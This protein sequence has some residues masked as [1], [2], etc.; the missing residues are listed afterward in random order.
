MQRRIQQLIGFVLLMFLVVGMRLAP[1]LG[2]RVSD[3]VA[4]ISTPEL[5]SEFSPL[6]LEEAPKPPG[7][8]SPLD[9]PQ[10]SS[11]RIFKDLENLAF[12]RYSESQREQARQYI[13]NELAAA[14]WEVQQQEFA[15]GINVYADRPGTDPEAGRILVAAHYD[16]VAF[17]PGADDNATGVATVLEVARLLKNRPTVRSL[18]VAFFDQEEAGLWGSFAFAG[19]EELR[20]NLKGVIIAD[21]IGY[22]CHV[23]GCQ[24]YPANI[25]VTPPSS[26]GDFIV[27]IGDGENL[28]LLN[29]FHAVKTE[30]IAGKNIH[31]SPVLAIPI[32][33]R[34]I[35]MPDTLR[36]DHAPFWYQGVGAVLVTDTA[37]LRNPHYH[38]PTDV[39]ENIDRQFFLGSAQLILNSAT[40]LLDF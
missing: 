20:A 19:N 2:N 22:A 8:F 23:P 24:S 14:G 15:G 30:A 25:P 13:I 17:S 35:L 37:N 32:P 7:T 1:S 38:Q 5:L 31:T 36:S 27:V 16:T 10:I 29:T 4:T 11:Q 40:A 6:K 33:F 28:P 18:S 21:M 34:G 39:V 26:K 9:F 12:E 3:P